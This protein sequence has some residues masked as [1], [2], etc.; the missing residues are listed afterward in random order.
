MKVAR[1]AEDNADCIAKN[2]IETRAYHLCHTSQ[3][4]RRQRRE[5]YGPS[6]FKKQT[7]M[8][9]YFSFDAF[10]YYLYYQRSIG[11]KFIGDKH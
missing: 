5:E 3:K 8:T 6:G 10:K 2:C 7:E 1:T 4:S 11:F 9:F